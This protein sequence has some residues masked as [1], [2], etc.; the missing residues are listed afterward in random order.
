[1][2]RYLCLLSATKKDT[3]LKIIFFVIL[4]EEKQQK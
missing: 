2:N 4:T 1:M 3:I